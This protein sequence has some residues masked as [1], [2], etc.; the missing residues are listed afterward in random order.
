MYPSVT[1]GTDVTKL[2][3]VRALS[4]HH[5]VPACDKLYEGLKSEVQEIANT[6]GTSTTPTLFKV[7]KRGAHV[8]EDSKLTKI[9]QRPCD[10]HFATGASEK[11]GS[12]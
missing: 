7:T 4:L 2:D 9:L 8:P 5:D 10:I 6:K 3:H 11:N 1:P 12:L